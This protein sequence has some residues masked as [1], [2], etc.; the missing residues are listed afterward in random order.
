MLHIIRH[1]GNANKNNNEI[2]YIPIRMAEIWNTD[3]IK[4][5][6]GCEATR[7]SHTLLAG[8]EN[9]SA[10]LEDNLAVSYKTKHTSII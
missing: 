1:Q 3:D 9:A 10:T 2:L 7:N 4:C 5:W 8:T 6:R